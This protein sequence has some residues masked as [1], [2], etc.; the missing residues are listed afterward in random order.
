MSTQEENVIISIPQK[1]AYKL[2]KALKTICYNNKCDKFCPLDLDGDCIAD[3]ISSS[4]LLKEK[5]NS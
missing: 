1:V 5:K 2:N 4:L 3:M